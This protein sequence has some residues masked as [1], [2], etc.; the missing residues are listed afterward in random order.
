MTKEAIEVRGMKFT[1]DQ[2]RA[3]K[4]LDQNLT[5]NAGAGSGKTRVL[6]ERY[7]DILLTPQSQ[8]GLMYKE[9]ALDRIVAITFTKKAAAEMKD[10][11]RERLT[12]YLANNLIDSKENQEERDWVFKLL[13]NLSKAKISTIH[14]FCSDII[15]NNLF[16]LGIKA[17]FSIMEGL[18]EKELQDEA[19]ST[20]LE[21]II[22]EPEDRL[23]KEL[24]EVT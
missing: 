12:E 9:D 10:R 18:E 22:N 16:E 19:I 6:T 23:Y 5:I 2:A 20:V 3:V 21:E 7:L 8:G 14:S 11:I 15:R 24:E 13:D 1:P 17:D 4:T